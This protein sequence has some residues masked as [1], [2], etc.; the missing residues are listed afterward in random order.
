MDVISIK[1]LKSL[2][3]G[4]KET[5]EL[6]NLL[7]IKK[8]RL[9]YMT[10]NLVEEDYIEKENT[11]VRLKETPKAI[12]F[13]D[14]AQVVDVEK[15]LCD[16][17]EIILSNIGKNITVD[18]LIKKSGLSK[19][20][21]YRSISDLQSIGSIL[22]DEDVINIDESKEQLVLFAKLLKTER[23]KK[24]EDGNTE[25]IYNNNSTILRKTPS[26]KIAK[27]ATTGFTL[28][29]DYG[30]GYRTTHDYF[31]EQ[32]GDLEIQDVLLHAV[33]SAN[34][35]KNKMELVIAIVFYAKHKDKMDILQ[36][37]KKATELGI[38][39]VWLDIEAYIRGKLLKN[40]D[41]FLPWGEFLSKAKLYGI[42]VEKYTLPKPSNLLFREIS[43]ELK[44][45]KT[46]Y[47]FGGENM[48]IKSLK[49]STKDCDIVVENK[50]DF[51]H[52]A[53]ILTKI[54]YKRILKTSYSDED[55]RIKPDDIFE[56]DEK[57]RIDLFTSTIMQDLSLSST[58]KE[59]ADIK[60]YGK[61]KVGLLRN[62]DIFLLKAIANR[63]G[64]IQDMAALVTGS[65]NTPRELQHGS[66]GWELVWEEILRQERNNPTKD[67]TTTIFDQM[68]YLAE[69][70]GIVAPFLEKLRRHVVDML[71]KRLVRGGSIPIKEIVELLMGGDI[72]ESMIRNR[73]DALEKS[74]TIQK[75]SVGRATHVKLLKDNEYFDKELEINI[76]RL[77]IYLDW[78]FSIREKQSDRNIQEF[79]EELQDLGFQTIGKVD[80]IIRNSTE[81]LKQYE[82]EQFSKRH[83]DA[84]GAARICVGLNYPDLGKKR[85]SKYF[86]SEF[87][88]YNSIA[89]GKFIPEHPVK[90]VRKSAMKAI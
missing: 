41:L 36:L 77:K 63:E 11:I 71:I 35:S 87:E 47:L 6:L 14:I 90:M 39:E 56:H 25:I 28:F 69:Q 12:L 27:G 70:T 19:A 53:Q 51:E 49:D 9:A 62:E 7:G 33:Y 31:C 4:Q 89:R 73:A 43:D 80:E 84:V 26:G 46:I 15:L 30:I 50:D 8:R 85:S 60:D 21:T 66:F 22:K 18:Q 82:D 45:S 16:S 44:E 67:F 59:R 29:S 3:E 61:L 32:K 79:V 23:E 48:R 2:V 81:I 57:S 1:L 55:K 68:S 17:N 54:G 78:R 34:Y 42:P 65:P 52:L 37:R 20:T 24:Y 64:G 13:R 72:T 76:H 38:L 88:K 74:E 83:F 40:T 86:L 75:Y 58:I 10:K 5:N